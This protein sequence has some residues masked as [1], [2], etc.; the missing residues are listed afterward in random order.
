MVRTKPPATRPN[1]LL[2]VRYNFRTQ[3]STVSPRDISSIEHLLRRGS[4]QIEVSE[5]P[6]VRD[7][8]VSQEMKDWEAKQKRVP[9]VL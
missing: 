1:F 8:W 2:F 6:G 3:A 5:D 7:I 9:S 4:R